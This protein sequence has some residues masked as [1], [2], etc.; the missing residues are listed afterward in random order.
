MSDMEVDR[1]SCI[2]MPSNTL[3]FGR[4]ASC[5]NGTISCK[6][7]LCVGGV[8]VCGAFPKRTCSAIPFKMGTVASGVLCQLGNMARI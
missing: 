6:S 8:C 2:L 5:R 1:Q 3:L 4:E 7:Y